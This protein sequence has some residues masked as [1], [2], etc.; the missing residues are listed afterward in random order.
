MVSGTNGKRTFSTRIRANLVEF[1]LKKVFFCLY[2]TGTIGHSSVKVKYHFFKINLVSLYFEYIH[3]AGKFFVII[4][5]AY[6]QMDTFTINTQ[7]IRVQYI[8]NQFF[9]LK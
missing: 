8:R 2:H 6:K 5:C 9:R 7:T 3:G 1:R 4:G